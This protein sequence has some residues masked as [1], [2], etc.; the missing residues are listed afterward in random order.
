VNTIIDERVDI[1]GLGCTLYC[2]AFGR[3]PFET[4]QEGVL[5]L[6]IINGRYTVPAGNRYRNCVY[7]PGFMRLI[8]RMLDADHTTRPFVHE[9]LSAAN[10]LISQI[11]SD[12][13]M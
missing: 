13:H 11:K 9:V 1:W 10:N 7:S 6:A 12:Q 5:R 3:S 4:P 8:E 2:L